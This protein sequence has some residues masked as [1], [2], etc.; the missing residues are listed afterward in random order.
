MVIPSF[1]SASEYTLNKYKTDEN[2]KP[3]LAGEVQCF[4]IEGIK[5]LDPRPLRGK[6]V[7]INGSPYEVLGVEVFLVNDPT[8]MKFGLAVKPLNTGDKSSLESN[9]DHIP[10]EVATADALREIRMTLEEIQPMLDNSRFRDSL[11]K[12]IAD[13]QRRVVALEERVRDLEWGAGQVRLGPKR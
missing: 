5:D 4:A 1:V 13:L 11:E 10:G 7:T 9:C 3:V 8:G 2:G 12:V 6:A